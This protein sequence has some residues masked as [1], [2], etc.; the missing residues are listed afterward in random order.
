MTIYEVQETKAQSM[1]ACIRKTSVFTQEK[2]IGNH[3]LKKKKKEK[4]K[5]L[6]N[7]RTVFTVFFAYLTFVEWFPKLKLSHGKAKKQ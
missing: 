3:W 5:M 7:S 4:K 6:A 2:V 1:V